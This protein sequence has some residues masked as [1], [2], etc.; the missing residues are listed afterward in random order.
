MQQGRRNL[1]RG[2]HQGSLDARPLWE[3]LLRHRSGRM[4]RQ[5]QPRLRRR[6]PSP[7]RLAQI[8]RKQGHLLPC[9]TLEHRRPP[10]GHHGGLSFAHCQERRNPGG[11]L[12]RIQARL[13]FRAMGLH[14]TRA[15]R[16]RRGQGHTKFLRIP[17]LSERKGFRPFP[18]MDD[19][20]RP[21]VSQE[22]PA[23][24]S[25]RLH[26]AR[27][28]AGTLHRRQRTAPLRRIAELSGGRTLLP[29][30]GTC[31]VL[32]RKAFRPARRL[33]HG[34]KRNHP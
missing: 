15:V 3:Q 7:C 1:H 34:G 24:D 2:Q 25:H 21:V 14:R 28:R 10:R 11:E 5:G 6:P 4:E 17:C 18:R 27:H 16:L 30:R 12:A 22:T 23:A 32:A 31:Q 8:C 19:R 13:H 20:L 9:R 29:F 33:L 26:D